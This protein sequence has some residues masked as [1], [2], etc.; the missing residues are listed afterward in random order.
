MRGSRRPSVRTSCARVHC[1]SSDRRV[2]SFQSA[3]EAD[4]A[5][6]GEGAVLYSV[7]RI[8]YWK[9]GCRARGNSVFLL[10]YTTM[11]TEPQEGIKALR[12]LIGQT[13]AEFAAM[14]GASK[15]TVVSW[16]TGRNKLSAAFARRI[17]LATGADGRSLLSGISIPMTG[18]G[19]G[20]ARIYA[21]EDYERHRASEWGRSDQESAKRHLERCVDTLELLFRAAA[22]PG[23]GK[24][25]LPGLVDSFIQW[26]EE[27]RRDFKLEREIDEQLAKRKFK[28]G[29]TQTYGEWR[30]MARQDPEALKAAG[31]RD[32]AGKADEERLRLELEVAP[33]WAPGRRMHPPRPAAM[34]ALVGKSKDSA[35]SG[36]Q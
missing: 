33:D 3:G 13:Q 29:V 18:D 32:S 10:N 19:L 16:E 31:F 8:Q 4:A 2:R 34:R 9:G 14:I 11:Q 12:N 1:C 26:S 20:E 25:R 5:T 35:R 27:A 15:D 23:R 22:K 6:A 30:R 28:A 17:E 21:K 24:P 36:R 7:I